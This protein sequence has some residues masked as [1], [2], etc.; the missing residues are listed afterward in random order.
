[1]LDAFEKMGVAATVI[2]LALAG[3]DFIAPAYHWL[4]VDR[5]E[6]LSSVEGQPILME[7]QREIRRPFVGDWR[8]KVWRVEGQE[9]TPVCTTPISR[10]NY[11]PGTKLPDPV[12]L[13]WFAYTDPDCYQLPAGD[14]QMEVVWDVNPGSFWERTVVRR[15]TF[16]IAANEG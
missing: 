11:K 7:Y 1:M 12:T 9:V 2:T 4:K 3:A 10:E 15:D 8:V 14:Y 6:V 5:V 16:R 13:E